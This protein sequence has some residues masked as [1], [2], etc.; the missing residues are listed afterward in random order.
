[1]PK[2]Y[3][4]AVTGAAEREDVFKTKILPIIKA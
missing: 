2:L 1:M 3:D 4:L